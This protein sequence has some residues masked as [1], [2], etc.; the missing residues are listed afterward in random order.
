[1]WDG[2]TEDG[3]TV[4]RGVYLGRIKA[5]DGSRSTSAIIKIAVAR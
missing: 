2:R 4:A 3:K 1:V 5:N